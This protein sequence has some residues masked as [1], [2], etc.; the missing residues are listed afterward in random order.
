MKLTRM[1][2]T[3]IMFDLLYEMNSLVHSTAALESWGVDKA[4]E[5]KRLDGKE[6][7]MLR[8]SYAARKKH[9]QEKGNEDE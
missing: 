7:N 8:Q 1:Q 6:Q 4:A 9:L 3:A 5:I 2:Q